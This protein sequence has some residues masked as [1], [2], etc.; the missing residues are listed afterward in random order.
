MTHDLDL[1]EGARASS[2][3]LTCLTCANWPCSPAVLTP[4]YSRKGTLLSHLYSVLSVSQYSVLRV[5]ACVF[6]VCA[7]LVFIIY[8]ISTV[9]I[10]IAIRAPRSADLGLPNERGPRAIRSP[11][12]PAPTGRPDRPDGI[13]VAS[14]LSPWRTQSQNSRTALISSLAH[15]PAYIVLPPQGRCRRY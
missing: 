1:G 13:L 14:R 3:H 5:L 8:L 9:Q 4:T 2:H 6:V 11:S 10:T 7:L 12:L 15:L